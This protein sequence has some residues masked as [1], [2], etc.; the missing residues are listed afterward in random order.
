VDEE[1]LVRFRCRVGHIFSLESLSAAQ[2]E[3]LESALWT[4][5]RALEDNAGLSHR[6]ASRARHRGHPLS[7]ARYDEMARNTE[8]QAELVRQAIKTNQSLT[9]AELSETQEVVDEIEETGAK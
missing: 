9:T 3:G 1:R 2:A 4:T 5:L 6:M 7:A 8:Q